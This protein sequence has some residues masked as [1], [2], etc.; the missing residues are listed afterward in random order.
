[1][2]QCH[3]DRL[4]ELAIFAFGVVLF[5]CRSCCATHIIQLLPSLTETFVLIQLQ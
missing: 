5:F 2:T 1:M 4:E 3:A